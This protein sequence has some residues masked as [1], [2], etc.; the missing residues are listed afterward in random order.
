ML[1][2]TGSLPGKEPKFAILPTRGLFYKI[3]N[4]AGDFILIYLFIR[5]ITFPLNF[6]TKSIL[7]ITCLVCTTLVTIKWQKMVAQRNIL[8][9]EGPAVLGTFLLSTV[10]IYVT[11][12]DWI[13]INRDPGFIAVGSKILWS[14]GPLEINFNTLRNLPESLQQI[15]T[16]GFYDGFES[17]TPIQGFPGTQIIFSLSGLFDNQILPS[18]MIA[19]LGG[20]GIAQL[21]KLMLTI[22]SSRKITTVIV[23]FGTTSIPFLYTLR[24]PFT[25]PLLMLIY[26]KILILLVKALEKGKTTK[27]MI[28]EFSIL[29]MLSSFVRPDALLL[30]LIPSL[31][32][33]YILKRNLGISGKGQITFMIVNLVLSTYALFLSWIYSPKYFQDLLSLILVQYVLACTTVI[34][35]S[36]IQHSRIDSQI[37]ESILPKFQNHNF[38]LLRFFSMFIFTVFGVR[39]SIE[40]WANRETGELNLG[41]VTLFFN[42]GPGIFCFALAGVLFFNPRGES[43][44]SPPVFFGVLIFLFIF[45]QLI[46]FLNAEIALDQ[47]WAIRRLVPTLLPTFLLLSSLGLENFLGR[48]KG[49]TCV[50]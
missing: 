26:L 9:G 36:A 46:F 44:N 35:I 30:I 32:I 15:N 17:R 24:T 43:L 3:P 1:G 45:Y 33:S 50:K 2:S 38:V 4:F 29:I 14:Y 18:A 27:S 11:V 20:A 19:I 13:S 16:L 39:D 48:F 8:K 41:T 49:Q 21:Y 22:T 37:Q 7:G 12:S 10:S 28:I 31:V 5:L 42:L 6:A 40:L 34:F 25:E 47:P 23:L